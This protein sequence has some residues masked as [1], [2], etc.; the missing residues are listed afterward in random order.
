M[1]SSAL[2]HSVPEQLFSTAENPAQG[3]STVKALKIANDQ[4][5]PIYTVNQQNI[6]TTLPQLQID[7]Q[8]KEDIQN[9]V[10]AGKVV[11]VS[12]TNISYN[13]W[14]GV[15]YIITNPET[16]AGAYMISGG[17]SGADLMFALGTLILVLQILMFAPF[18]VTLFS[19]ILIGLMISSCSSQQLNPATFLIGLFAGAGS[20]G[21]LS[22]L[23]TPQLLTMSISA[24]VATPFGIGF[25]VLASMLI[26]MFVALQAAYGLYG[27][28]RID[29]RNYYLNIIRKYKV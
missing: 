14:V 19:S 20:A 8:S 5:I 2:E 18:F 13:G 7:Q 10:N 4:G 11:T 17:T 26:L 23:L 28:I 27:Y 9:A 22:S 21:L 1:T 25:I 3:I 24:I 16:G 29:D 6:A 12:K 15:G